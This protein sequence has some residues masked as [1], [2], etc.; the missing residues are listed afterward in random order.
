MDNDFISLLKDG[1]LSL[2]SNTVT[3][4]VKQAIAFTKLYGQ[5]ITFNDVGSRYLRAWG[6]L[7]L[8]LDY[9]SNA[10]IKELERWTYVAFE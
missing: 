6:I 10:T 9:I 7:I 1:L 2:N 4:V 3:T 8:K 5:R